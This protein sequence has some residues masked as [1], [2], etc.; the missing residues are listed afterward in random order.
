MFFEMG[1]KIT[2][3]NCYLNFIT[4]RFWLV[5]IN[6]EKMIKYFLN[7]INLISLSETNP[8][9]QATT[10]NVISEFQICNPKQ[11]TIKHYKENKQIFNFINKIDKKYFLSNSK[12][13]IIFNI[14]E[15]L[16]KLF[17]KICKNTI[18]LKSI[19]ET[20][21][22][23]E[24]GKNFIKTFNSG[25]KILLGYDMQAYTIKWN[26]SFVDTNLK[27]ISRLLDFFKTKNLIYLRRV[28]KRLSA[29]ISNETFA[30]TKNIY[31]IKI[32]DIKYN[33]KLILALLNSN[34][35]NF[36]YLNKFTT[37]KEDVFPEIQ[38]YLYEQLPIPEINS[39]NKEIADKIINNVDEI[40]KIKNKNSNADISIIEREIDILVYELYNLEDK[41]IEAIEK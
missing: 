22:G 13:E 24:Y 17:D 9:E 34:L 21:R 28:D 1:F 37:K 2:K 26:N 39:K 7:S 16:I 29:S 15:N 32:T 14:N 12:C 19:I 18:Q 20:K 3:H 31:G 36:Y 6:C 38:T 11:N 40:L 25:I 33:Y 23:A 30:F 4:P 35:L 27:D 10:E 8:F 41:E 5:N